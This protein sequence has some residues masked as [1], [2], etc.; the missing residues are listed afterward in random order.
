MKLQSASRF[1][2]VSAATQAVA[3]VPT[4]RYKAMN[5]DQILVSLDS[6]LSQAQQAEDMDDADAVV[7][8]ADAH[9]NDQDCSI[10]KSDKW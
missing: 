5:E 6:K 7:A 9:L 4:N 8:K 10:S 2:A 1:E 3:T